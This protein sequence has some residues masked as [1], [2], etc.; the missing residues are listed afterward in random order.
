MKVVNKDD[1]NVEVLQSEVPVL[2]DFF[3]TWC[4]P[5]KMIAPILDQV[6]SEVGDSAKIFKVD[7]DESKELAV[8]YGVMSVPTIIVFKNGEE[9]SRVVGGRP[10]NDLIAML[11]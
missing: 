5:C 1:F 9:A 8:E 11:K 6:A 10:K 4:G 7:I 2:V 3:A